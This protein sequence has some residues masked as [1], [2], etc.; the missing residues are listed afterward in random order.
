M[1]ESDLKMKKNHS[2][3]S[4][5]IGL[6][7]MSCVGDP[8][9]N[10]QNAVS[11]IRI[12]AARGAKIVCL[13]ELFSTR[14]FCR[15]ESVKS[16]DL[17]EKIPGPV[18]DALSKTAQA[19]KTVIIAPLFEKATGGVYYNS[20]VVIDADGRILGKYRKMHIPDDP[21]FYEK[22]YFVPGDSGFKTFET[23]YAKIGVLIC[24]DQWFPEAARLV[25]L[26]G[27]EILFYPT[28]IG[29][30]S[31]KSAETKSYRAAWETIQRAHAIANGIYVAAVNRVGVEGPLK[32]WG[33]SFVADPFGH[34]PYQAGQN[35]ETVIADCDLMKVERTRREW[36][37]LRDR[38][39]DA[40]QLITSRAILSK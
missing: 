12:A 20:A 36:P 14:Y 40:Y 1:L 38:R 15:T 39:I 10:I 4:V 9:A 27:A 29:W 2:K 35:P 33:G 18:T 13:Q 11:K 5:R 31:D 37:F 28:A 19:T 16:F 17:A 7:Q 34:V 26:Q 22:F 30:K 32:F 3:T 6:V 25:A 24:W 8:K 23:R 21:G